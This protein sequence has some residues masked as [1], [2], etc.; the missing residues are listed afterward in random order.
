MPAPPG[1]KDCGMICFENTRQFQIRVNL[2]REFTTN[3]TNQHELLVSKSEKPSIFV[4]E[5]RAN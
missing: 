3:L 4:Q 5:G 2:R 1:G